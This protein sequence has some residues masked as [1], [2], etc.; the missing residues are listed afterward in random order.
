M[1]CVQHALHV[2]S[3]PNRLS[4]FLPGYECSGD[5][6]AKGHQKNAGLAGSGTW[7]N[8]FR[9]TRILQYCGKLCYQVVVNCWLVKE[10]L[11]RLVFIELKSSIFFLVFQVTFDCFICAD[12]ATQPL[13]MSSSSSSSYLALPILL[14]AASLLPQQAST[15]LFKSCQI[16]Y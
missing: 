6:A 1:A 8:L 4:C 11:I 16:F 7:H 12:C 14:A 10:G 5:I 9:S 15:G 13:K 3:C 2:R